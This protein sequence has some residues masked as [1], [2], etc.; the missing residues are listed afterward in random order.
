M[1]KYTSRPIHFALAVTLLAAAACIRGKEEA[2][3]RAAEADKKAQEAEITAAK[4]QA[5]AD[6]TAKLRA[7]HNDARTKLQKDIDAYERKGT[8]L[9]QK[10]AAVTGAKKKNVDA[11]MS[12][13]DGRLATAKADLAKLGD[14]MSP[15]WD[16]TRKTTEDDV[17]A[18]GKSID[19]FER[20]LAKK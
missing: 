17:A 2:D 19:A 16:A 12:E 11:A 13:Y 5:D 15:A 7:A 3:R 9:K 4:V 1:K 10:A 8:Y 6:Q 18:V 14:D 20:T